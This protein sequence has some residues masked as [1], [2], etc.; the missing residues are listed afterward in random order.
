MQMRLEMDNAFDSERGT[1]TGGLISISEIEVVSGPRELAHRYQPCS[2]QLLRQTLD[3][4]AINFPSYAFLDYGSGKGRALLIAGEYP[5]ATVIGVEFSQALC[6]IAER[7]VAC[8]KGPRKCGKIEVVLG[9]AAAYQPPSVPL[10]IFMY[11]PFAPTLVKSVLDTLIHSYK[12]DPR[13]MIAIYD[14]DC[15]SDLF[16]EQGFRL[17]S[18]NEVTV[19]RMGTAADA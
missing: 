11:N 16:L 13:D 1:D 5:F 4:L 7:N 18:R 15:P 17:V 10:V 2:P 8:D 3:S 19:F 9:D 14:T 6:A 12:R